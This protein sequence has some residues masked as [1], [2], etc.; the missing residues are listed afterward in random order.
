MLDLD[1]IEIHGVGTDFWYKYRKDVGRVCGYY[2]KTVLLISELVVSPEASRP[3]Q[4]E[5]RRLYLW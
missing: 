5:N 4:Q 1:I 2:G 3:I